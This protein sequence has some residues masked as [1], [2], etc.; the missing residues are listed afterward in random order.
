[1]KKLRETLPT[2][3]AGYPNLAA[4]QIRASVIVKWVKQYN[5]RKAQYQ[6]GHRYVSSTEKYLQNEAEGLKQEIEQYH[7]LG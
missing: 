5:L 7:P 1:M 3:Q 6:A 4:Q 2:G